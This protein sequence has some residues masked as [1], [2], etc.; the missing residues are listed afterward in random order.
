M[1]QVGSLAEA[2]SATRSLHDR[3]ACAAKLFISAVSNSALPEDAIRAAVE[4]TRRAAK[5]VF[6]HANTA[7]GVLA[8]VR[9]V[10]RTD[11]DTGKDGNS[12]CATAV[13]RRGS[14]SSAPPLLSS[15]PSP[16]S[17]TRS[18]PRSSSTKPPA[19]LI[20]SRLV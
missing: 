17:N 8:A 18:A 1:T 13:Y 7:A 2:I 12:S 14:R 19:K 5:P 20:A 15:T 3:A 10:A 6:A 11:P 4:E 9:A 16:P